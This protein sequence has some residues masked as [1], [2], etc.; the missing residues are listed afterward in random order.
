MET[1][2]ENKNTTEYLKKIKNHNKILVLLLVILLIVYIVLRILSNNYYSEISNNKITPYM[3]YESYNSQFTVYG[4]EQ[5]G[6]KIK[7][8]MGTLIANSNTYSSESQRIPEII[9]KNN[10]TI[11]HYIERPNETEESTT[12]YINDLADIRNKLSNKDTYYV[13]F[14]YSERLIVDK[15]IITGKIDK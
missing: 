12:K 1:N 2:T 6:S 15:I 10:G 3:E 14:T 9:V 8:L 13:E 5:S 4:G 11:S 7:S